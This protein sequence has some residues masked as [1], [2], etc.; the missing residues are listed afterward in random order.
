M[1][2][3][4][5]LW[6]RVQQ[7][8][9]ALSRIQDLAQAVVVQLGDPWEAL[10]LIQRACEEA[11]A[12]PGFAKVLCEHCGWRGLHRALLEGPHPFVP[13]E[14]VRGCPECRAIGSATHVCE[15]DG[16]WERVCAGTPRKDG[17]Y[18]LTCMRHKPEDV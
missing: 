7:M 5:D 10:G 2:E 3:Q 18:V 13:G 1:S 11:E 14:A 6:Q 12:D 17:R 15:V 9:R 16:C 8:R 4:T